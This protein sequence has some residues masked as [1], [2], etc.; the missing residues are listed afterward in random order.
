MVFSK[1][2]TRAAFAVSALIVSA[3]ATAQVT[4]TVADGKVTG[5]QNVSVRGS[6]YDVVFGDSPVASPTSVSWSFAYAA[7]EAIRSQVFV[8]SAPFDLHINPSAMRGCPSVQVCG[9]QTYIDTTFFL[10]SEVSTSPI[11]RSSVAVTFAGGS[12]YTFGYLESTQTFE[13][14]VDNLATSTGSTGA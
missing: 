3:S 11:T 2:V 14:F 7:A 13:E 6:F 10:G 8:A 12:G 5:A 4:W 9:V 1:W